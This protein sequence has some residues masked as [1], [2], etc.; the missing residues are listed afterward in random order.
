[1]MTPRWLRRLLALLPVL[2][3]A[4]TTPAHADAAREA[5]IRAAVAATE[6]RVVQLRYFGDA[7]GGLGAAAPTVTGYA[8]GEGWVLTSLYALSEDPAAILCQRPGDEPV[9]AR[10]VARDHSRALALLRLRQ[11]AASPSEAAGRSARVGETAI[12]LG[13]VYETGRVNL[14]VGVVSAVRRLGGRALQTDAAISPANY[15][16]P[17]IGLDGTLLGLIT[18]LSPAGQSGVGL[19]DSGVGFAVPPEQFGPRLVRLAAGED[20]RAGWLG[21]GVAEEDPLRSP[22]RV[23]SLAEVGPAVEAGLQVGDLMASLNGTPTGTAWEFRRRLSGLDAGQ[24]VVV[25]VQREGEPVQPIELTLVEQPPPS[26]RET[27]LEGMKL[28]GAQKN[29]PDLP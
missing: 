13:R 2:G 9:E 27:L 1:M 22:A 10:V 16:G 3:C 18:P 23:D 24:P 19:Y 5:A 29:Q 11:A 12:A 21:V 26:P 14:S 4:G 17:L 20:V 25:G 6:G 28:K 8:I 15:G 7:G